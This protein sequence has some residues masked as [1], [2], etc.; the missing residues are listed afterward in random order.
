MAGL[1]N[2]S[3]RFNRLQRPIESSAELQE[4]AASAKY[5]L[6]EKKAM[7]RDWSNRTQG[8]RRRGFKRNRMLRSFPTLR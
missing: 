1:D 7:D 6:E 8:G 4:A 2:R 3:T 5:L